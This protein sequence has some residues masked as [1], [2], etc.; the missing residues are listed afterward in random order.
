MDLSRMY[1]LERQV[2]QLT[3]TI[4]DLSTSSAQAA[5]AVK[6]EPQVSMTSPSYSS[7]AASV[8][9]PA[10]LDERA[11]LP[12][13]PTSKLSAGI[14]AADEYAQWKANVIKTV[15]SI[16]R[17]KPLLNP[18]SEK[19]WEEF[20]RINRKYES[21]VEF[22]Q[23]QYLNVQRSLWHF[24]TNC[25]SDQTST[26]FI[27][28]MKAEPK[29]NLS[30]TLKFI[31]ID[32]DFY[33]NCSE[34]LRK[35]DEKYQRPS[36][37]R[38]AELLNQ[39]MALRYSAN[40][41]PNI[42]LDGYTKIQ[43]QLKI[44][45]P[46][47]IIQPDEVQAYDVLTRL[48]KECETIR[49]QFLNPDHPPTLKNVQSSLM[50]W[51]QAE[52]AKRPM[53]GPQSFT[54]QNRAP[55]GLRTRGGESASSAAESASSESASAKYC[56]FC[57]DTGHGQR[58]CEKKAEAKRRGEKIEFKYAPAWFL[59]QRAAHMQAEQQARNRRA[60]GGQEGET[61]LAA[62]ESEPEDNDSV[63]GEPNGEI[64]HQAQ[65]A[66]NIANE[67][68]FIPQAHHAIMDSGA[69]SH[70]TGR[71][72]KLLDMGAINP[73]RVSTIVGERT[74]KQAGAL[75]MNSRITLDNVK[76][77]PNATFSLISTGQICDTKHQVVYT[78]TAAYVL[79]ANTLVEAT[80]KTQ[81]IFT[82]PR[83]GKLWAYVIGG[84]DE[85]QEGNANFKYEARPSGSVI[86]RK[87]ASANR[88]SAD[89]S[90]SSRSES[91]PQSS[92]VNA[93][94]IESEAEREE[95]SVTEE[96]IGAAASEPAKAQTA[97]AET[98]TSK[99][100]VAQLWHARLG[101]ASPAKLAMANEMYELGIPKDEIE[102]VKNTCGVC[103][104]CKAQRKPIGALTANRTRV[105][106]KVMDC[107]HVDLSGPYSMVE[108]GKRFRLP[109]LGGHSYNLTVVD[110]KSRNVMVTNL[111]TKSEA[112]AAI[113]TLIKQK[114]TTLGKKLKRLHGDG[115]GEFINAELE[116]FLK[117]NG[118]ELTTTPPNTPEYNN[119]AERM[120]RT[121]REFAGCLMV[122]A[123]APQYLWNFAYLMA[124]YIH[125]R[126]PQKGLD[127]KTP[128]AV[129]YPT[130]GLDDNLDK[131]HVFGCDA[132]VL[133]EEGSKRGKF[134]VSHPGV[135]VGFSEQ[136]GA[137]KV[138]MPDTLQL[139]TSRNV[140]FFEHSFERIAAAAQKIQR[141]AEKKSTI[142]N[143][144][145]EVEAIVDYDS[146]SKLY[147]IKWRKYADTT[148]EP[149]KNLTNCKAL[150]KEFKQ[151]SAVGKLQ[152]TES[153]NPAL[154]I[155]EY[156]AGSDMIVSASRAVL[157][158]GGTHSTDGDKVG[159]YLPKL[160][161]DGRDPQNESTH[162]SLDFA[163]VSCEIAAEI[164]EH[165]EDPKTYK[166]AMR[167]PDHE[168]WREAIKS[169]FTSWLTN[170]AVEEAI[171]PKGRKAIDSKLV[172]KTKRDA[173]NFITRY[174]VRGVARGFK[175]IEGIDFFETFSPTVRM[176]SIKLLLALAAQQDMEIKQI[177]FETAFLNATLEE[178]IY[179]E[180][181]PGWVM[182]NPKCNVL[183]LLKALY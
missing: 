24:L 146:E 138:L 69:T 137:Y 60:A 164:M 181:P 110:E 45:V 54:P 5:P 61:H 28:E 90:S 147:E 67:G 126:L 159:S 34:L 143:K 114:Q 123:N 46:N 98:Q 97:D 49:Y 6:I 15:Q 57:G 42:F 40:A 149:E 7:A 18:D 14:V 104:R 157:T 1:E 2:A 12:Q 4:A 47:Y 141:E 10:A 68:V 168:K 94:V 80:I 71:D 165:D 145:Y 135:F 130:Q 118:T 167:R 58:H 179:I 171:L 41:D 177:D 81:S 27:E 153:A 158:S 93:A 51:F 136:H 37:W 59:E 162:E 175:Q 79:P 50:N 112:A 152:K 73:V 113:I 151:K 129:M 109:S 87:P 76:Y 44:L 148:W 150:L 65:A 172:F 23:D 173:M 96:F 75:K 86:G 64:E 144:Q 22:L 72:D 117:D 166:E 183:R 105:A 156:A 70:F 21:A 142:A 52:R 53:T 108:Q 120:N 89:G 116:A 170:D 178:E 125:N 35:I 30:E 115:G 160:A 124:A 56:F 154:Q 121:L 74:V 91:Q 8:S 43:R 11:Q 77:L 55:G 122:N 134:I 100:N 20:K 101:H 127:G 78:K 9:L 25:L 31:K 133:I 33:E 29:N 163:A 111:K 66:A 107:W 3:K 32:V 63:S 176:K 84:G 19:G 48:P 36:G 99:S 139:V 83:R 92:A 17:Y 95:P 128:T 174:K 85:P 62:V 155:A 13:V 38:I 26:Q 119:I 103:I 88:Q 82:V 39:L 16:A 180:P 140:D 131:M 169:E 161:R 102:E 182:K 132:N 106:Q